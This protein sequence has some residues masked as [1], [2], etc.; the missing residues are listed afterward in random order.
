MEQPKGFEKRS[1]QQHLLCKLCKS[2]YGLK[3]SSRCWN[4]ALDIHLKHLGFIQSKSD[5]YIYYQEGD[6]PL[7]IGVYVDDIVLA[8]KDE[9]IITDVKHQLAVKFDMKDLGELSY[10]L[11]IS[12]IQNQEKKTAWIGQPTY[13]ETLLAK[14][15]MSDCNSVK[16][17]I[18]PGN[19]LEKASDEESAL[20]QQL[21]RSAVGSLLYLATCMRPDIAFAVT[22]L[23]RFSSK[24]KKS[25]WIALKRILRYLKGTVKHRITFDGDTSE[26]LLGNVCYSDADWAEN[27]DDRKSTSGYMYLFR[28]AGGPV[29]WRN[30]KARHCGFVYCGCGKPGFVQ[31]CS[32]DN[33]AER[34]QLR[35]GKHARGTYRHQ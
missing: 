26:S 29:S 34:A 5:P 28:I 27:K 7:Y 3:Q 30:K 14:M 13:T 25:H 32:R 16:T 20:D 22:T 17:P 4:A 15:G 9:Q 31:C 11:G 8:G 19:H 1:G 12:I 23:G 35:P 21:Y 10:F 18:D 24:P 6:T 33:E 2:I